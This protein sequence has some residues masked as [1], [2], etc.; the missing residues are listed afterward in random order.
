MMKYGEHYG[1]RKSR[2]ALDGM[3]IIISLLDKK[4]TITTAPS[5]LDSMELSDAI[6]QP[7]SHLQPLSIILELDG[8]VQSIWSMV[9]SSALLSYQNYAPQLH[10]LCDTSKYTATFLYDLHWIKELDL[11]HWR[12][13]REQDLCFNILQS[14]T[15]VLYI[16]FWIPYSLSINS[17]PISLKVGKPDNLRRFADVTNTVLL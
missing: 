16:F 4:P 8:W 14:L 1:W 3:P 6:M 12:A 15:H 17:Q 9:S 7:L 13:K 10:Q 11:V 2:M 5:T